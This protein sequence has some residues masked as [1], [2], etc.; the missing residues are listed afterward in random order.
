[1][2]LAIGLLHYTAP[3]VVG[4]VE[5]VIGVHAR[6]MREAGHSVRV[7]AGRGRPF[8]S[9]IELH[10]L[11][12]ADTRH[13]DVLAL[14]AELAA[15]RV[16]QRLDDLRDRL[17]AG[18]REA[19]DGLDVLIAHNVCS[20]PVNLALTAALDG[21]RAEATAPRLVAWNHDLA[22]ASPLYARELHPGAPWDLL[23]RAWPGVVQ[24]VISEARRNELV[25][26]AGI[27]PGE[28]RVV[29]NG[30]DRLRFLS[31]HPRTRAILAGLDLPDGAPVLLAPV[32]IT[33]R[34]N[35]DVAVRVLAELRA[36]GQDARLIVTG[37]PD[38]HDPTSVAYVGELRALAERL[39]VARAVHL[40]SGDGAT[41]ISDRA[42]AD[43]YRVADALFLPSRSEGFGLPILEAAAC[44][45][46]VFCADLAPIREIAGDDA[47]YFDPD[48][49]PATIAAA[50]R[51]GLAG[52]RTDRL[53]LRVRSRFGWRS[54]YDER[55]EPLLRELATG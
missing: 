8:G 43:L 20:L 30:I 42:V 26:M 11:P 50:V 45:L 47:V 25:E 2:P 35:L 14:R 7:I 46:P 41:R 52:E 48:D 40:L 34:K 32:R 29:P 6:L 54:I 4:G 12:L 44:R 49:E 13:P 3:P 24:V 21:L 53:A 31:I 17:L 10:R 36:G 51:E 33:P 16:T 28:V 1:V 15:G 19:T 37:P 9:G 39:G 22:W 27:G 5:A 18:L 23:A 55:I 38:P